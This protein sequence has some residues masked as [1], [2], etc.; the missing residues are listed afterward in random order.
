MYDPSKEARRDEPTEGHPA[1]DPNDGQE[2]E[3]LSAAEQTM[4][5]HSLAAESWGNDEDGFIE[6]V[7][8]EES[9]PDQG[10]SDEDWSPDPGDSTWDNSDDLF[11]D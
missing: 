9:N 4:L 5:E 10:S 3:P 2:E 11:G 1:A 8:E 7:Q 6:K